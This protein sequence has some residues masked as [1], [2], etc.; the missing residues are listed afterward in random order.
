[1]CLREVHFF[2]FFSFQRSVLLLLPAYFEFAFMQFT[3]NQCQSPLPP[4]HDDKTQLIRK[5]EELFD[6]DCNPF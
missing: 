5:L 4:T 6:R 2:L 3:V 1:M